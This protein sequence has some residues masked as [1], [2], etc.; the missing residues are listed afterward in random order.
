MTP[1]ETRIMI[2]GNIRRFRMDCHLTQEQLAVRLHITNT[3]LTRLENGM[4]E[5]SLHLLE[6]LSEV[7]GRDLHDFMP[8]PENDK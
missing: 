7:L 5:P 8:P 6:K 3:Y 4:K 1:K 2:G